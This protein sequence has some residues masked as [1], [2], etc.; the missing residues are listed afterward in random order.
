LEIFVRSRP[1]DGRID[2]GRTGFGA[3]ISILPTNHGEK[4]VLRLATNDPDEYR[5]DALGMTPEVVDTL[6]A[7]LNRNQGL[8]VLTGPTGSGKTTTMYAS[9]LHIDS[10]RGNETNI[11]TLEDPIE[12][13]F[14]AFSQTQIEPEKGMTFASGLRSLLRQDPDV[15]LVGEIRDDETADICMRAATTGHLLLT[16]V[17]ADC[18]A[19]VFGR[20]T[21]IGAKP[22]QLA[23]ATA[24]VLSQ[25][26]CKKLCAH[27]R[28]VSPVTG[29]QLRQLKLMGFEG[30]PDGSFYVAAGCDEC[31]GRGV[32]G[33]IALY[34][35]LVVTPTLRDLVAAETPAHRLREAA[36]SQGMQSL[37]D[38]GLDKARSGLVTLD[39][40]LRVATS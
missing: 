37:L 32:E 5:I 24:A 17:H 12:F 6:K 22:A 29:A 26:L 9:L 34:E 28:E 35:L 38:G 2:M 33:R 19:S 4:L 40:V 11:T 25:R 20:L 1:Q 8:I 31:L 3:R 23:S 27:C 14:P 36:K 30:E 15:I 21:Q 7:V 13:D 39:E 18:T 10:T 16:T